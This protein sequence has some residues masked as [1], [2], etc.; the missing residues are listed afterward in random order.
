MGLLSLSRILSPPIGAQ[1][2]TAALARL[3][4][5]A[6]PIIFRYIAFRV[7]DKDAAEILTAEL[8]SMLLEEPD[9]NQDDPA[10]PQHLLVSLATKA[11]RAYQ[12]GGAHPP[13]AAVTEAKIQESIK[14]LTEEYQI[15]LALIYGC[16]LHIEEAAQ[17]LDLSPEKARRLQARAIMALHQR[18]DCP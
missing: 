4:N 12:E 3:H 16:R 15:V 17:A 6:Y 14:A 9:T 7:G 13:A 1:R 10:F 8:F 18:M 5:A 11:V 2:E